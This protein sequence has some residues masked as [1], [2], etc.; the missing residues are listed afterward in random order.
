MESQRAAGLAAWS[1][2]L[3]AAGQSSRKSLLELTG[4]LEITISQKGGRPGK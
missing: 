2:R 4:M 1:H 3:I